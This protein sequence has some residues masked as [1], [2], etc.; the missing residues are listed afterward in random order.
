MSDRADFLVEIGTEELPPLALRDLS[1]AFAKGV[2]AGLVAAGLD[3]EATEAFAT[4]RRLAVR[5]RGIA[6]RQPTRLIEKRG[7]PVRAAFASDGTP[8]RAA[9]AFAEG[10]GVDVE[11][12]ERVSTPKAEWLAFRGEEPGQ[13]ATALLPGI[14]DAALAELPVPRRMRW[15][16]GD[17]EFVRPVHWVV[18]LLGADV[19]PATVFGLQ[20]G[21]ISHGHRFHHPDPVS[22]SD[23]SRYEDALEQAHVIASF[24]R[25]RARVAEQVTAAARQAGGE[26]VAGDALLD[27]VTA[28]VE[29]PVAVAARFDEVYLELPE[30][31]LSATLQGHQ[32]YF[33]VRGDAGGLM[34]VF[35]TVANIESR[36]VGQIILGNERVVRPR[37]ADAAFFWR[38]DAAL[39]LEDR[40]PKLSQVVYQRG[41]G[42][43]L[44]RCSR[45]RSLAVRLAESQGMPADT[46]AR[47]ARLAKADLLTELVGEF[48]ELQGRVGYYYARRDGEADDVA[49]ALEEQ[50]LPRHAGDRLP[51]GG[52][53]RALALA[54]RLDALAGAFALG[55]RPSGN[56]D[57]FGLRRAAV[58]ILRILIEGG[59]D[60]ELPAI[61]EEAV[62][63]QPVAGTEAAALAADIYEFLLDRLRAW[64]L[65]GLA[66]GFDGGT[67]TVEEFEAVRAR[68]PA[69]PLDFHQRMLAVHAFVSLPEAAALAA[70]NK[71]IANILRSAENVSADTVDAKRLEE[72]AE[73]ALYGAMLAAEEDHRAAVARR[74]YVTVLRGLSALRAPV[75]AFF[76]SV[77][78]MSEEPALR[79]NRL[80]LLA[81][82]RDMFLDVAD[83]SLLPAG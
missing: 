58:G 56:R 61:L 65:E 2:G 30:E 79:R 36:D 60:L 25:R 8:T 66:P 18:M 24:E 57:P 46:T 9:T 48:P 78:V 82:L 39:S 34:S 32:R 3:G 73:K 50:Y 20:T 31:V 22:L 15:G 72:A 69:S 59:I 63:L 53:G 37:L 49:R 12:L 71:R 68:Q 16:S 5:A 21:R 28:L 42:T 76:D 10:C 41:L 80:A 62:R 75:D 29:W 35:V 13:P 64:Y 44:E 81:R 43:V 33:P 6:L 67:V 27:E 77:L 74:D 11:A 23:P 4:P 19:V 26:V 40:V 70:A 55:R 38:Q 45:V 14:V 51:A 17:I 7:P 54:D 83:A 47:A 1:E 52:P